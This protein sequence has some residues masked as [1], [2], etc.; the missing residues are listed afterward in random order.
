[1]SISVPP[2]DGGLRRIG[3]VGFLLNI[4]SPCQH[5]AWNSSHCKYWLILV[6]WTRRRIAIKHL[7]QWN[8]HP[9]SSSIFLGWNYLNNCIENFIITVMPT[10][11][12]ESQCGGWREWTLKSDLVMFKPHLFYTHN[13]GQRLNL[14]GSLENSSPEDIHVKSLEPVNVTFF[15]KTVFANVIKLMIL[16]WG[17][18]PGLPRWALNA[19]T[20]VFLR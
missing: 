16:R 18:D 19:I 6:E 4:E 1:M 13:P 12:P 7:Y 17:K 3:V 5:R 2:P 15:V 20:R 9:S 10:W 11:I 8:L 14:Y